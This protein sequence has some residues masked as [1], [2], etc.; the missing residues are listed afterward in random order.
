MEKIFLGIASIFIIFALHFFIKD[1]YAL[2]YRMY[3]EAEFITK[4]MNKYNE[5]VG[6]YL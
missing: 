2:L 4:I 3:Y 5:F 1:T 6:K